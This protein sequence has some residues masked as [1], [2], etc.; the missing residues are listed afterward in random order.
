[1]TDSD[2]V[3]GFTAQMDALQTKAEEVQELLR[4]TTAKASAPDGAASVTVGPGGALVDLT[5][6]ERAYRRRP[7]ALASL[8]LA[9]V[10]QAQKQVSAQVAGA[11]GGL[12]GED[13]PAMAVVNEFLPADPEPDDQADEDEVEDEPPRPPQP[14]QPPRPPA[15][16]APPRPSASGPRGRPPGAEA[17]DDDF[18]DPW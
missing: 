11:F 18:E 17:E 2:P 8:V 16:P 9:L 5:F 13:S 1:V 15:P 7:E 4:T 12:V 6:G 14:P 3:A 10:G